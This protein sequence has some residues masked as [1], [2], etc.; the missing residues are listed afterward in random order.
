MPDGKRRE[1]GGRDMDIGKAGRDRNSKI[2]VRNLFKVFGSS[3]REAIRRLKAGQGKDEILRETGNVVAVDD[4]SFSVATGEIFVV[5]GL[6]GSGKSTLIRCINR[7]IEPSAGQILVDEE[8]IATAGQDALRQARL[9]KIAMV[10]Q[11]FALFPHRTV[12]E[13]V[14]Y[15]LKVRGLPREV[16]R[17]KA[18]ELLDIVGLGEWADRMPDNLS[19]GM[20]QRVGL[21]RALAV[22]PQVLL[23]DEPFGALDPLIRGELQRE[24]LQIQKR[25]KAAIIFI[26]HDLNEALALGDRVAI[27]RQGQFIQV[28]R[29]QEIVRHPADDYVAAFTRD[30]DRGRLVEVGAIMRPTSPLSLDGVTAHVAGPVGAQEGVGAYLVDEIGRPIGLVLGKDLARARRG[31]ALDMASVTQ[32]DFPSINRSAKLNAVFGPCRSGKP[33]AVIDEKGRL[34][35][36]VTYADI[37]AALDSGPSAEPARTPQSMAEVANIAQV[38]DLPSARPFPS[39]DQEGAGDVGHP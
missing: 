18:L 28:G 30:V 27:M 2:E 12:V 38:I 3:S 7:L 5:M 37:L 26:T 6:S 32:A 24:L 39:M 33:V 14:E 20:R 35:G 15:G 23:M 25:L 31:G 17:R 1:A 29:G 16:R 22:D 19:G 21:A 8:D 4:V 36:V 10:F 11:H 13:N 9:H 34:C